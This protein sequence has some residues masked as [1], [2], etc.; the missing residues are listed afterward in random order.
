M[1]DHFAKYHPVVSFCYFAAI[2][3]FSM[4]YLHPFL[5]LLSAAG[6]FLYACM[7][8]G[9]RALWVTLC[10]LLPLLLFSVLI[11][12]AF[13]HKGATILTYLPDGNPLTAESIWFGLCAAAMFVT[14]IG[15]CTCLTAVMTT[16]KL[17]YL[18]GR[19]LPS[20]SLLLSMILSFLPRCRRQFSA[21]YTAQKQLLSNPQSR[22]AQARLALRSLSILLTHALETSIDTADSMH[23]R[24]FGTRRRTAYSTFRFRPQDAGTLIL[25]LIA[26]GFL[27]FSRIRC[28]AFVTFFPLFR[29]QSPPTFY[30]TAAVY[31][32]LCFLPAGIYLWEEFKWNRLQSSI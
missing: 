15:W 22:R 26:V 18:F 21:I 10:G 29:L 2:L 11:N 4:V 31:G 32:I 7:Q 28:G 5:L 20:L 25:L 30:L 17:I 3:G 12:V 27:L 23:A 16:D 9:R 24:G 19:P 8:R 13:N 14:V 6:G 1:T